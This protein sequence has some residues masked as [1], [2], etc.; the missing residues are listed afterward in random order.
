MFSVFMRHDHVH[1]TSP[2]SPCLP[3]DYTMLHNMAFS[4]GTTLLLG[5]VSV[6]SLASC[7]Q[8][9]LAQSHLQ[10]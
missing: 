7:H 1:N 5:R 3:K 4:F 6:R 10:V 2:A 9:G 8:A